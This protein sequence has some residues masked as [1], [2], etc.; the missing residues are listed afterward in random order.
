MNIDPA[1]A[2]TH[3]AGGLSNLVRDFGTGVKDR[4][5]MSHW[6]VL[7]V[8]PDTALVGRAGMG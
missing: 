2:G 1:T 4:L 3:V 7:S 6:R 8:D 5:L